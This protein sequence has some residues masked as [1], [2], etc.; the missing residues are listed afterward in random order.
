MRREA[1][2]EIAVTLGPCSDV[3]AVVDAARRAD[4]AGLDA[5][6]TWDHVQSGGEGFPIV[7]GWAVQGAIALA[8]SRIRITPMVVN[9]LNHPLSALAKE[10][11]ML[12]LLSGGRFELGIGCG[13]WA[14]EQQAWGRTLPPG[15]ERVERL[16]ATVAALRRLWAGETLTEIVAGTELAGALSQPGPVMSPR[17]VVGA[18]APRLIRSAACWADG[19]NLMAWDD[20]GRERILPLA[21]EA[22]AEAGREVELSLLLMTEDLDDDA[23]AR[24]AHWA[25]AGVTRVFVNLMPPY[26]AV[27]RLGELV[28][29]LTPVA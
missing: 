28:E 25:E 27:E 15:P 3:G 19:I 24:L 21:R 10:T 2:V 20:A 1:L 12:A 16:A 18:S 14:E 26:D 17:V 22:V 7:C 8:T 13:I 5:V 9:V 4:A 11:S 6:G 29:A 23:G